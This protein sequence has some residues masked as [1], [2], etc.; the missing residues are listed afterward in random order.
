[1]C[2]PTS[3]RRCS[4]IEAGERHGDEP[5]GRADVRRCGP[6]SGSSEHRCSS[7]SPVAGATIRPAPRS[8][9]RAASCARPTL[10]STCSPR[11]YRPAP[12]ARRGT[13]RQIRAPSARRTDADP[14]GRARLAR[15][16]VRHRRTWRSRTGGFT[17]AR[18]TRTHGSIRG[19]RR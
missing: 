3:S 17:W 5:G 16:D 9:R 12:P 18:S 19:S 4:P 7:R 10:T 6:S 15:F 8:T 13:L 14:G 2:H 11:R 1:M